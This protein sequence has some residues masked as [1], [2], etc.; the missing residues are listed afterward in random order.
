VIR[1]TL[2]QSWLMAIHKRHSAEDSAVNI[3]IVDNH[4]GMRALIRDLIGH[5]ANQIEECNSGEEA[6]QV[7]GRFVPDCVTMDLRMGGMNGV[8]SIQ[9]IRA[10]HPSTNIAVVTQFDNDTLR[11]RAQWAGADTYVIK[12]NLEPLRRFVQLVADGL[13]E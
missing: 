9:H 3:L 7:C 13:G 12:D 6:I 11:M 1:I 2:L 5:L 4:P 8:T 10:R